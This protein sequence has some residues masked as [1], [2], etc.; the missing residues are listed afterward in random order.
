M[1]RLSSLMALMLV[2][3]FA[4]AQ[5]LTPL[6]LKPEVKTGVLPNGLTYYILHNEQPKERANFYIAQKVG[7][8]LETQ[9]QL[10]LAHFLEHMA[11][12]GIT[13]YPGKNMLN[14]LQSKGIRFGADINAYTGFDETVY[15]INNV[16]TTDKPLMDS[17]L[18]VIR[19]W[20]DGILLEEAEIEAERGVINEEWRQRND[21]QSRMFEAVLP[22]IFSEY[23]YQQ[24]PIGKMEVVMN[25]KPETLR[26][27]YKKWY[28]PDQQGIVIVGD[29][30]A[31]EMEK[32]VKELFSTVKLPENPAPREYVTI[33]DNQKPIYAHYADPELGMTTIY[34]M[35]K[36]DKMPREMRNTVEGYMSEALMQTV[37]VKMIQDRLDEYSNNPE[38][39]YS[40]AQVMLGDFLVA[41][42]KDAFTVV[43]IP[44]DDPIKAYKSAMGIVTRA[45]K[46]GFTPTELERANADL[47]NGY[48]KSFNER[49]KTYSEAYGRELIR[50]FISNEPTPGIETE[51]NLAKQL[52]PMIPVEAYN[53]VAQQILTPEN[54]VIL[55][56]E[57]IVPNKKLLE[58]A[59]M[60]EALQATLN[61]KYEA[62]VDEV[63]TEPLIAKLPAPGSVKAVKDNAQ[64]GTKEFTLSNGVK[65]ILKTTDFKAD[66]I[67]LEA[68]RKGGKQAYSKDQ[69]ANIN[70]INLAVELSKLGN[71]DVNKMKK[72]LVGKTVSLGYSLNNYT[73]MLEGSSSVKD[74]GTLME[75][76]YAYFT[77]LN[78]DPVTYQ[79]QVD[80][81][82]PILANQETL[83]DFVFNK[84]LNAAM[85]GNN[86]LMATLDAASLDKANYDEML[87]IAKKSME[88][89]ADYTFV[90]VGNVDEAT[91]KPLLEQYIASLPSKG[92]PSDAKVVT[93]INT[94]TGKV[95]DKF[96]YDMQ[97]PSTTVANVFTG[98]NLKW[99]IKNS[100]MVDLMGD[101]LDMIFI[102]TLREDE[103]GTYGASVSASYNFS[104]NIWRLF[105]YYKTAEDKLER[106][107]ARA[108][109][110]LNDLLNNG[111]K[112][113]HF[114]KVKEAAIK[115][116]EIN[117]RT[118]SYWTGSI[119]NAERGYNTY[120]GYIEALQS[121]TLDEF[122]KFLKSVYNGKNHVEVIMVGKQA[123]D[124]K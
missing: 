35:F 55:V 80:Q 112:A 88:N 15:N 104:N 108:D 83:P 48:E 33:S 122:N 118:N 95:L 121:L 52:L 101:V 58:E 23:Q 16:I 114:N 32:K 113:D 79:A 51:L 84:H 10:G 63:I 11:F 77:E 71:F 72:Y 74:F 36:S 68:F 37:L 64:M 30:D 7:S 41:V 78:P 86:P 102:E 96:D 116:Y 120:A 2:C 31:D 65:V 92:K 91:I 47:L 14:Y 107:E 50:H 6:A 29:F 4:F 70:V 81:I 42:T 1:K 44:K 106:L 115:Q 19:D 49:D 9:E 43:V 76:I 17:V 40:A 45:C 28:R 20:C 67:K 94:V 13:H 57:P 124:A 60:V 100:I 54:E 56:S 27:Y 3:I 75:L 123:A 97:S 38:C 12:N 69:A 73:D 111:A 34:T 105:Y 26:A 5:Q 98:N 90:F 46:T 25:F 61:D 117:S 93:D 99:D 24:T 87:A 89:A 82:K 62:Y 66:E 59:E 109:K 18:L 85:Y 119:M 53:Q 21:A 103:G 110:E 8:A 22:Q 39:P